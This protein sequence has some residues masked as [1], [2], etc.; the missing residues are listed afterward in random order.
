MKDRYSVEIDWNVFVTSTHDLSIHSTGNV[1]PCHNVSSVINKKIN[2][3]YNH[4]Y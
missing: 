1:I 2:T 3:S 4:R